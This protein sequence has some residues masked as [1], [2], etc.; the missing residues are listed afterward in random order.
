MASA[1]WSPRDVRE[2]FLKR[3]AEYESQ[4]VAKS[5]CFESLMAAVQADLFRAAAR[6]GNDAN[7]ALVGCP[8]VATICAAEP[9]TTLY[10][11]I[12]RQIARNAQLEIQAS[13]L[14]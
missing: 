14:D 10:L 12:I 2:A 9:I 4:G 1:D 6:L 3:I 7:Q 5:Q 8:T 11:R 13:V